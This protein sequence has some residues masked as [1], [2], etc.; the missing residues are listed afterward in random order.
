MYYA[1]HKL[2]RYSICQLSISGS[3]MLASAV[4]QELLA[5]PAINE[6]MLQKFEADLAATGS[7]KEQRFIIRKM[8]IQSGGLTCTLS[9]LEHRYSLPAIWQAKH[10]SFLPTLSTATVYQQFGRPSI[11]LFCQ[12]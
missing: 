7:E 2:Q 6:A 12:L 1:V 4:I 11:I 3:M 9:K 8:L 10:H 5:L